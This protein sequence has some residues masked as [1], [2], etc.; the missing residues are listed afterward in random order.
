MNKCFY[1]EFV[2][3]RTSRFRYSLLVCAKAVSVMFIENVWI[4]GDLLIKTL[5]GIVMFVSIDIKCIKSSNLLPSGKSFD[6]V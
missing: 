3:K 2:L 6:L 4:R 5:S 1:V